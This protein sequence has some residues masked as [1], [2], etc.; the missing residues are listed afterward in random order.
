MP[1]QKTSMTIAMN[2]AGFVKT[3]LLLIMIVVTTTELA[4][5][6]ST[7]STRTNDSALKVSTLHWSN[8][9]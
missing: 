7:K 6:Q 1:P 9:D 3:A 8:A 2:V 5:W 4:D